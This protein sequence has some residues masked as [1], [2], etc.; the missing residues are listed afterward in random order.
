[1][2]ETHAYDEMHGASGEV[3]EHYRAFA[4]WLASTP[5]DRL[6]QKRAEADSLFHRL[7]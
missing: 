6:A 3:R 2:V 1:M 5:R 7:S 4:D